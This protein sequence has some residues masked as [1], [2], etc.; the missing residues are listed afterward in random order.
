MP[1]LI[2]PSQPHDQYRKSHMVTLPVIRANSRAGSLFKSFALICTV[3]ALFCRECIVEKVCTTIQYKTLCQTKSVGH[4]KDE[5]FMIFHNL[6]QSSLVTLLLIHFYN[7][8][9]FFPN[10]A[11]VLSLS[12]NYLL[13]DLP[14]EGTEMPIIIFWWL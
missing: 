14:S 2:R 3:F 1:C 8:V 12:I 6:T 11:C 13:K 4:R 9:S 7:M 10:E 5:I